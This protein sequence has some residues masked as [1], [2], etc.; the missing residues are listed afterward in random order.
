[1]NG[2]GAPKLTQHGCSMPIDPTWLATQF[3]DLHNLAPIG[4]GGQKLVFA[5]DHPAEGPVVLK[6]INPS[7]SIE[8]VDREIL[9]VRNVQ[10]S[11]VP[12]ILASGSLTTPLGN[13]LWLREQRI[14]GT[15][16]RV[17]LQAG[18]MAERDVLRLG[19]QLLEALVQAEN[20]TIV[21]RDVKPDNIML[22]R[23]GDFWL[24]D[25]GLAR[26]LTLSSLTATH[27][28][29]GKFTCGYAPPEQFRNDK[30]NIDGR[31][32]LF[33]LG[34][35]LYEC[36]TSG[37]PFRDGARDQMEIL[38]RV[39]RVALPPLSVTLASAQEIQDFVSAL[40]QKR[41]DRR[42][43]TVQYAFNWIEAI[44]RAEQI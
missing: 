11:R 35:T 25:F 12:R 19:R 27:L 36:F 5:A 2:L 40:T 15:T 3:P 7:Q 8:S 17:T 43:P 34:V 31:A 4:H 39:D 32:D 41:R 38:R 6:L 21:H 23:N 22:D 26:H 14:D 30:P 20:A 18:P 9:A 28:A 13:C 1:M 24:L 10:S 37:N 29:W 33:G 44:C 42:P 16:L